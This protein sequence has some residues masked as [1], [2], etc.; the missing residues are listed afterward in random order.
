[1]SGTNWTLTERWGDRKCGTGRD[2]CEHTTNRTLTR[3]KFKIFT[4]LQALQ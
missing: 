3:S 1:M 4:P 2:K